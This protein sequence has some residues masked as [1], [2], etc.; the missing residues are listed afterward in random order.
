M[1][2]S[3]LISIIFV[4]SIFASN[5]HWTKNNLD[6]SIDKL[7]SKKQ[8]IIM[9]YFW[10]EGC[11]A[12]EYM[13]DRVFAQEDVSEFINENFIAYKTNLIPMDYPVFA[14]PTIYFIDENGE[15]LGDPI[16]GAKNADEFMFLIE[17]I[18]EKFSK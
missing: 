3:I 2:K 13:S 18:K 7:S 6:D 1:F 12:C 5:I 9:A 17:D 11:N 8:K 15:E 14:Y 4:S 16:M 10:L